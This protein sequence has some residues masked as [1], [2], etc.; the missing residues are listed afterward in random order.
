MA[1]IA[2]RAALRAA[3]RQGDAQVGD[4]NGR[5]GIPGRVLERDVAGDG[6]D[7]VTGVSFGAADD[8]V[9]ASVVERQALRADRAAPGRRMGRPAGRQV[10][11]TAAGNVSLQQTSK[12][13]EME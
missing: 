8:G 1:G 3:H 12:G 7:V 10:G 4:V 2:Q 11:E 6:L 13:R 5:I 9:G